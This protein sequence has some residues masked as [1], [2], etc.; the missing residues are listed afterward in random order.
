M[1]TEKQIELIEDSFGLVIPISDQAASI[2]YT[3]LFEILPE[4]K[5]L[6]HN[7]IELQGKKLMEMLSYLVGSLNNL[8]EIIPIIQSLAKRH[9]AYGI[10]NEYYQ[11]VGESLLYTLEK[12]LGDEFTLEVKDAWVVLYTLL[13]NTMIEASSNQN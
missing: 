12:G 4:A 13:S 5:S 7:D 6:F 11:H 3:R 8:V 9:V 1:L 10:K 2:F